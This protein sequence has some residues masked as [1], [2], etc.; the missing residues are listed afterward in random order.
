MIALPSGEIDDANLSHRLVTT[1]AL[2]P[3]PSMARRC[4]S[5]TGF[6][7]AYT[8]LRLSGDQIALKA[9]FSVRDSGVNT[10]RA[11]SYSQSSRRGSVTVTMIH[12]PSG[13]SRGSANAP[14]A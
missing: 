2:E 13:D 8:T 14:E 3:L 7:C 10:P 9:A 11:T 12:R 4:R 5:Y 1:G 6:S